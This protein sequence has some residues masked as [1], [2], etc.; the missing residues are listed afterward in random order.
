MGIIRLRWVNTQ[1]ST[2][3]EFEKWVQ[4]QANSVSQYPGGRWPEAEQ[5]IRHLLSPQSEWRAVPIRMRKLE[6]H[7]G[8]Q[9]RRA[10]AW[11]REECLSFAAGSTLVCT[12]QRLPSPTASSCT[13][14]CCLGQTRLNSECE[15]QFISVIWQD[16]GLC[17]SISW[18][19]I[20]NS[21]TVRKSC[22][23]WPNS[24]LSCE[25]EPLG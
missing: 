10:K 12:S 19:Q 7:H 13:Q 5:K 11:L 3:S 8:A 1:T 23:C 6:D 2:R 21:G 22:H 9:E 25:V 15:K 20:V 4:S 24:P 17:T 18:G 16:T 14:T